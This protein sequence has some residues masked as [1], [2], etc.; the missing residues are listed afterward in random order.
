MAIELCAANNFRVAAGVGRVRQAEGDLIT[1]SLIPNPSLFA[2]AQLIPLQQADI[3]NQLGP[4]Q[5]DALVSFPI[6]W[7]LFGKRVAAVQAARLGVEASSA[8]HAD[9]L[10][11]QLAQTVDAFYEVL[12]AEEFLRLAK[13]NHAELQALEEITRGLVATGKAGKADADRLR[14]ATLEA[15]LEIHAR[16]LALTA[17]KARLRPLIGRSAA[18][19]DF[20][21]KGTLTV[22]AVVPPPKLEEAVA[23]AEARR[24]DLAS[25][26]RAVAQASAAAELERRRARP[27]VA[28]Q[29]GWSYQDQRHV[30]GFRNGSMFDIGIATTL[31]LTDRNQGNL[32]KARALAQERQIAYQGDRAD[33]LAEVETTLGEYE[34]AVEDVTRNNS[35][36]TLTAAYD[37]R[38][39]MEAEFRRG[40]RKLVEVLS[41]QQAYR[42]RVAHVAEFE[43]NYWRKL[44]KLNAVVGLAPSNSPN[45]G[46][47]R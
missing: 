1:S 21:V 17:A 46:P 23:L 43:A 38:A 35:P 26:R 45:A 31:P 27:Q 14:L 7:L 44:N 12:A 36:A 20:D 30:T 16:D 8:G 22:R 47:D 40:D 3:H 33:A 39:A 32:L 11:I 18:D 25:G 6:D 24:P 4:P 28:V 15:F 9:V 13:E 19:P 34:D 10:R 29:P 42:E 5:F 2:D 41:A 37:L